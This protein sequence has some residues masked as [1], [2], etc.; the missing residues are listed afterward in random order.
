VFCSEGLG[1]VDFD[2][3][4]LRAIGAFFTSHKFFASH[5]FFTSHKLFTMSSAAAAA[6]CG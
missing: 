5:K 1:E 4:P 2:H 3:F 6:S